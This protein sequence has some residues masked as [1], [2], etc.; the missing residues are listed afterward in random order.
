MIVYV[1][2]EHELKS[3]EVEETEEIAE[4]SGTEE[5]YKT[6]VGTIK[7]PLNKVLDFLCDLGYEKVLIKKSNTNIDFNINSGCFEWETINSLINKVKS[8]NFR[9]ECGAIVGFVG[10]VREICSVEGK[11]CKVKFLNFEVYEN[12]YRKKLGEICENV[13]KKYKVK[14]KIF[15]KLGILRPGEDIVYVIVMGKTRK[16]VWKAAVDAVELMKKDLPVWKKEVL[17]V[18][19]KIISR[20]M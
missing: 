10:F 2:N 1:L 7:A 17:E 5:G 11:K 4:I 3:S 9:K 13:E 15:H 18:D 8:S 6:P 14:V 16:D 20:W 19:G 12:L